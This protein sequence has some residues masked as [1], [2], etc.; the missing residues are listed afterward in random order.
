MIFM[1]DSIKSF[2]SYELPLSILLDKYSIA[3]TRYY[4]NPRLGSHGSGIIKP[5]KPRSCAAPPILVLL[6]VVLSEE[7]DKVVEVTY[8][9]YVADGFVNPFPCLLL[10]LARGTLS[11]PGPQHKHKT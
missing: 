2:M 4:P 3:H 10:R 6:F 7:Y 5:G 11:L 8:L 1:T 9:Q